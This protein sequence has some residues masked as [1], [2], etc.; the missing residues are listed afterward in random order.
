MISNVKGVNIVHKAMTPLFFNALPEQKANLFGLILES[1]KI[2]FAFED[3]EEG[4]KI[5]VPEDF[6]DFAYAQITAYTGEN[7]QASPEEQEPPLF[8]TWSGLWAAGV[9]AF[10]YIATGPFSQNREILEQTGASAAKILEGELW[11]TVTALCLHA[12]ILH[13]LGNM[14]F[15]GIFATGVCQIA[16]FGVGWLL[17]LMTGAM[18]NFAAAAVYQAGHLSGGASTAVFGALGIL[19]GVYAVKTKSGG[20]IISRRWLALASGLALLA[21]L[22]AGPRSDLLAHLFGWL[23]GIAVGTLYAFTVKRPVPQHRQIFYFTLAAAMLLWSWS[24]AW[25]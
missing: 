20:R 17:I 14:A 9:L 18:G 23:S 15:L 21:F 12:D 10:F 7:I 2:P 5:L 11:R 8:T 22:G 6:H 25:L 19:G 16:G 3:G 1:S 24:G 4:W 13:L